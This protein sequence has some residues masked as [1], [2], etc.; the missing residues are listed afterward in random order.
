MN[1]VNQMFR[2]PIVDEMRRNAAK[3]IEECAGD[4]HTLVERLR[5][6]QTR[7]AH[8]VVRRPT[9][10]GRTKSNSQE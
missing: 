1:E 7:H 4:V 5:Q 3:L 6:E 2:D 9:A 8:R 10:T